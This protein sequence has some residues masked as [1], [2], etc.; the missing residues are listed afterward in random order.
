MSNLKLTKIIFSTLL[1][2]FILQ[3]ANAKIHF[4]FYT[5]KSILI[6]FFSLCI[7][8]LIVSLRIH[9]IYNKERSISFYNLCIFNFFGWCVN[10]I[11]IA[12][13]GELLKI[14][15][16]RKLIVELIKPYSCYFG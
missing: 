16:F 14:F 12:G 1:F 8:I 9:I 4:E 7:S 6:L 5:I 11:F 2:I 3:I 15:F 10:N 13:T